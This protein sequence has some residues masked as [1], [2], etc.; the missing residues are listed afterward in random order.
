THLD[1][2]AIVQHPAVVRGLGC[3]PLTFPNYRLVP[4]A[5]WILDA[6]RGRVG[7]RSAHPRRRGVALV[8]VGQKA[9]KRYGFADGAS[10]RTNVPDPD[11]A[12]IA[13][14]GLFSAYAACP[15]GSPS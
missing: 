6:P 11:F 12:P 8:L 15:R 10:P 3:G 13:R 14:H 5:R 9:L 4:D 7:A 1:L 2:D